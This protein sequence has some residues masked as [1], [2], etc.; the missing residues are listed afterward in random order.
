VYLTLCHFKLTSIIVHH[1]WQT[2][3]EFSLSTGNCDNTIA[4]LVAIEEFRWEY[5]LGMLPWMSLSQITRCEG[6]HRIY[7]IV[8]PRMWMITQYQITY[9]SWSSRKHAKKLS[10][11]MIL[12]RLYLLYGLINNMNDYA[13]PDN[14][15]FLKFSDTGL[16]ILRMMLKK[17]SR[18]KSLVAFTKIQLQLRKSIAQLT[19]YDIVTLNISWPVSQKQYIDFLRI[20][21]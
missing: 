19:C 8:S 20:Y 2:K 6:C 4:A 7:C 5:K 17:V 18:N 1:T 14:A 3:Q 12:A 10:E 9:D 15:W 11:I 13:I 16:S 21:F